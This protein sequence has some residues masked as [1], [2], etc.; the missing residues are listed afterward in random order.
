MPISVSA[1]LLGVLLVVVRTW[2]SDM[3]SAPVDLAQRSRAMAGLPMLDSASARRVDA[4][5]PPR[6][7]D[8]WQP[9]VDVP[10]FNR[11]W[12][13]RGRRSE[14]LLSVLDRMDMGAISDVARWITTTGLTVDYRVPER[15]QAVHVNVAMRWH[16]DP[17]GTP[18]ARTE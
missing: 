5:P 10:G 3:T 15:A 4:T 11:S 18:L 12:D 17:F 16:I 9:A 14:V 2:P 7:L 6:A 13:V 1:L 8:V